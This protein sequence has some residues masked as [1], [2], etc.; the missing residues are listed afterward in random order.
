MKRMYAMS[1]CAILSLGLCTS[2][3]ADDRDAIIKQLTERL[4]K[5]QKEINEL[6][7]V[8]SDMQKDTEEQIEELHTRA[9]DNELQATLNKVK[10]G[11]DFENSVNFLSGDYMGQKIDSKEKWTSVFH[12]NMAADVNENTN[13]YGRIGVSRNWSDYTLDFSEDYS[14]EK[15]RKRRHSS[16]P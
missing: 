12:L 10:F 15:K 4:D 8:A 16:F 7:G 11:F 1:L 2:A 5:M 9:D 14:Q 13:F 3:M 6:K